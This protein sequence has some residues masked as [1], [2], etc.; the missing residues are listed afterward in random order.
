MNAPHTTSD[1]RPTWSMALRDRRGRLSRDRY[2]S[3]GAR[4]AYLGLGAVLFF[5]VPALVYT[6]VIATP[7]RLI[8]AGFAVALMII[9]TVYGFVTEA[10]LSRWFAT[11]P[12]PSG[13]EVMA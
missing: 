10:L 4:L 13:T 1:D 6:Q 5:A 2:R 11:R 8:T 3:S 12:T 7:G 9:W